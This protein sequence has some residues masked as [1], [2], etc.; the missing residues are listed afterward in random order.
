MLSEPPHSRNMKSV[1]HQ[2]EFS[3]LSELLQTMEYCFGGELNFNWVI[4]HWSSSLL[5]PRQQRQVALVLRGNSTLSPLFEFIQIYADTHHGDWKY[6]DE[7]ERI[8]EYSVMSRTVSFFHMREMNPT[9]IP[10]Y[11]LSLKEYINYRMD[12]STDSRLEPE[13]RGLP[14]H[15][16]IMIAN[17]H[18]LPQT[19]REDR[20]ITINCNTLA[21]TGKSG[22]SINPQIPRMPR[23]TMKL[24]ECF[25]KFL[26]KGVEQ[27]PRQLAQDTE[28]LPLLNV[29]HGNTPLHRYK[30]QLISGRHTLHHNVLKW[31]EGIAYAPIHYLYRDYVHWCKRN[32]IYA[33]MLKKFNAKFKFQM[34]EFEDQDGEHRMPVVEISSSANWPRCTGRGIMVK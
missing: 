14:L 13:E 16:T 23:L 9:A 6:Q 12:D 11:G 2:Q 24:G 30:Q 18:Q 10:G 22:R 26:L 25:H 28:S 15:A 1:H 3:T 21:P 34:L 32:G 7:E 8:V 19:S 4:G 33:E 31:H 27:L 17:E 29:E 20:Y 5:H